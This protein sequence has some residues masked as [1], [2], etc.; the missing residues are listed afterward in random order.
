MRSSFVYGLALTIAFKLFLA[1]PAFACN[2]V[3]KLPNTSALRLDNTSTTATFTYYIS[4]IN[5]A[6]TATTVLSEAPGQLCEMCLYAR[7]VAADGTTG[8]IRE[9]ACKR[10]RRVSTA[11][12]AGLLPP[13]RNR[14]TLNLA[15]RTTCGSEVIESNAFARTPTCGVGRAVNSAPFV[16]ILRSRAH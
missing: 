9:I 6:F 4:P 11:F 3:V 15:T 7:V 16:T 13:I 14:V 10:T 8:R 12:R 2:E 5:G 1:L